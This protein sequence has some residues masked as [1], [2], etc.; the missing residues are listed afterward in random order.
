MTLADRLAAIA[1]ADE[2]PGIGAF[3]DFD[4]TIID[5]F[6]AKTLLQD[7]GWRRDIGVGEGIDLLFTGLK[8]AAGAADFNNFMATGVRHLAG[9]SAADLDRLGVRLTRSAIGGALHRDALA[10]IEAHHARGHTVVIATSA[11][12]YQVESL[13]RELGIDTVLCTRPRVV[14]GV[15]DG[16]IDGDILWGPGKAAAVA[17]LA[18]ERGIELDASFGY[19][20]GAEDV[21]FLATIGRPCAVNPHD[22]LASVARL[23]GWP[24]LAIDAPARGG[25]TASVRTVA[26]YAGMA[27]AFGV[28]IGLGLLNR[29][30][31]DAVNLS[32]SIGSE[33]ALSLAGVHVDVAGARHLWS[34]RPAVFVFNHQS[35][36]DGLVV[37]KLLGGDITGVAKKELASQPGFGQFARL[38]NMAFVDRADGKSAR[39]ALEPAVE[40]LREGYSI[41]IAPEGTRSTTPR[42]GPFKK[43]AFHLAMQGGVPIVPIV[44]RNAGD[45]LWRGSTVI[46][47]GTVDVIVH[48]PISVE[49]WNRRTL[50]DRVA[51]VRD[52]F[53]DTLAHWDATRMVVEQ[54]GD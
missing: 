47:P 34:Q 36:L 28:G 21:Q 45:M 24:T 42:V 37:M 33:V 50:G 16:T 14:R 12:P 17:A 23:S 22:E 46:Q 40:R 54:P 30:R 15:L 31:R 32:T 19:G 35:W 38:A 39:Q 2:G 8:T 4:G 10:L 13:A 51:Q 52:L 7:R 3:F 5:G 1:D 43:G 48:A 49:T 11:L 6:S 25:L 29:S 18:A 26:A 20:N 44:L 53:V 9:R 27:G 41:V